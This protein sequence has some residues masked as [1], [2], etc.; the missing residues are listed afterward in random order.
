MTPDIDDDD[1][2]ELDGFE[3]EDD[4]PDNEPEGDAG[5]DDEP[6]PD[7][8]PEDEDGENAT[9]RRM[10]AEIRAKNRELAEARKKA[11]PAPVEVGERPR[12]GDGSQWDF[13]EA[14]HEAAVD[15]WLERK[16]AAQQQTAQPQQNDTAA[17]FDQQSAAFTAS[18]TR[19][20]ADPVKARALDDVGTALSPTQLATVTWV[21]GDKGPSVLLAIARDP[22]LFDRVVDIE[23]PILLAAEIGRLTAGAK[24][25]AKPDID[26]PVR[27]GKPGGAKTSGAKLAKLEAEAEKTGDRTALIRY[28]KAQAQRGKV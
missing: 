12:Y 21:A 4:L 8:Q 18:E 10:R 15:A 25:V 14:K 2:L 17:K 19:L 22:A 1:L 24:T 27:G 16:L 3:A 9:I 13:D 5:E 20:R 11:A 6:E 23:D 7:D 28:R 26:K